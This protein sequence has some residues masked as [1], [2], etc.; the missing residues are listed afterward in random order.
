M[1]PNATCEAIRAIRTRNILDS[2]FIN[3]VEI[4]EILC[5]VS[6]VYLYLQRYNSQKKMQNDKQGKT[7]NHLTQ[8]QHTSTGR[9]SW[10]A[11]ISTFWEHVCKIYAFSKHV[12]RGRRFW[13]SNAQT[14]NVFLGELS[15]SMVRENNNNDDDDYN[16]NKNN[17]E[18]K[19]PSSLW[20]GTHATEAFCF[21]LL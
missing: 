9:F 11:I 1:S 15:K 3:F 19:S 4:I 16:D 2:I 14:W 21:L 13:R 18:T 20:D 10:K 8:K 7:V 5:A 17:L 6:M 12:T